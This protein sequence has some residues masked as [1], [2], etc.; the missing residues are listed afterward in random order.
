MTISALVITLDE[1]RERRELALRALRARADVE[2]GHPHGVR[3]PV[4][5]DARDGEAVFEALR[6]I[7]GVVHVDVVAIAE[8]EWIA[9]TS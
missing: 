3:V 1:D 5:T 6:E 4:V 8:D 2:L 7:D 9:E